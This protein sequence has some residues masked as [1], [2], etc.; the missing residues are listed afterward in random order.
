MIQL[1]KKKIGSNIYHRRFESWLG[2]LLTIEVI[3]IE[4]VNKQKEEEEEKGGGQA[5]VLQNTKTRNIPC[6]RSI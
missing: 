4:K 3:A 5:R 2:L 1:F 6:S